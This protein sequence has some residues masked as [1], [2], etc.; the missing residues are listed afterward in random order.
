MCMQQHTAQEMHGHS[1]GLLGERGQCVHVMTQAHA[2]ASTGHGC[3]ANEAFGCLLMGMGERRVVTARTQT[4]ELLVLRL[5]VHPVI[6]GA[7]SSLFSY[8]LQ[9]IGAVRMAAHLQ[10]SVIADLYMVLQEYCFVIKANLFSGIR[11]LGEC[12]HDCL[13]LVHTWHMHLL[14][15]LMRVAKAQDQCPT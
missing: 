12:L 10:P 9:H 1:P 4:W 13:H 11:I 6:W 15:A 5:V 3:S 8:T 2:V 14:N 7:I